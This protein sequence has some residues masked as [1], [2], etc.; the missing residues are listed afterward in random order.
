MGKWRRT[1]SLVP[2]M[3]CASMTA[4]G[5]VPASRISGDD[6]PA[7]LP[8][9]NRSIGTPSTSSAAGPSPAAPPRSVVAPPDTRTFPAV[10]DRTS[11]FGH[12]VRGVPLRV[13]EIG[14]PRRPG[15]LVVG[16]TDGNEPAGIAVID[17]LLSQGPSSQAHLWLVATL[18]PDGQAADRRTNADRVDLN[19]YFPY[20]RQPLQQPGGTTYSGSGPLSEPESSAMAVL[21]RRVHPAVGV[22]FHQALNVIDVSQGPRSI[23]DHLAAVLHISEA[24][25]TDYPGSA[26]G[27]EGQVN[28]NSAFAFALPAGPLTAT[29]VQQ[30]AA[31]IAAVASSPH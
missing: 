30:V 15:L 7:R 25:L 31:A 21:L 3:V 1:R 5:C 28:P 17:A 22:W 27:F 6:P 16:C 2:G 19:R 9:S 24:S 29:R 20:L 13:T 12:S 4:V 14:N 23:E 11:V 8:S 26:I 18:N 10:V